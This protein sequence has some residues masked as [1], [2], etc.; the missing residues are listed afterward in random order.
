MRLN[1]NRVHIAVT[2]MSELALILGK[3]SITTLHSGLQNGSRVGGH[4]NCFGV[5]CE[6]SDLKL[7]P[8]T[9]HV[10]LSLEDHGIPLQRL[11]PAFSLTI[12]PSD[13]YQNGGKIGKG[14]VLCDQEWSYLDRPL[15]GSYFEK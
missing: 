10:I 11:S 3:G 9:Y 15:V 6:T 7:A 1:L 12:L 2:C 13:A 14:L 5:K 4:S 8:G